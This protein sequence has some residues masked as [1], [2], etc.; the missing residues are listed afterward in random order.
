MYGGTG[1]TQSLYYLCDPNYLSLQDVNSEIIKEIAF[2]RIEYSNPCVI[3]HICEYNIWKAQCSTYVTYFFSLY[4][5]VIFP[6]NS[7]KLHITHW[8]VRS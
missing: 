2:I 1:P 6:C 5:S 7:F 8:N 4:F 3:L